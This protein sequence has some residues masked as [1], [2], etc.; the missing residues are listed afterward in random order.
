MPLVI[1]AEPLAPEGAEL[2]SAA[3]HEVV[4]TDPKID[5]H[6]LRKAVAPAQGL[7]VRSATQVDAAL[8]SEANDLKIIGRAGVGIDN[9]DVQYAS[10]R[11]VIVANAPDAN[12]MSAAE[13]TVGLIIASARRIPQ[14]HTALYEGR[15]DR[16]RWMGAELF[17]RTAGLVGLGRVGR[18][19]AQRLE[20][21][22][23][24]VL[25]YDP[26]VTQES[27]S[28]VNVSIVSDLAQ[29]LSQSDFVSV[30]MAKTAETTGMLGAENLALMK[31]GAYLINTA[32]GGL[33]DE[34]ALLEALEN[35]HLSGAAIDTWAKEPSVDSPL[36]HRTDV[37]ALPHLGASTIEAQS[38]A[39]VTIAQC[40][41]DGLA[42]RP[43]ATAVNPISSHRG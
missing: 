31:P 2:L 39:A 22:G 34:G 10:E 12:V 13:L 6:D 17:G 14:A 18:L 20:A 28:E 36:L 37:I 15:W 23:M 5:V 30:H 8:L 43:V 26:Y 21:F 9:I 33:V 29:L 16:S 35:G 3:G 24:R 19:V 41:I 42:G 7:I 27:A 25:A 4:N 11:G 38:R 1:I 40:V 32:R